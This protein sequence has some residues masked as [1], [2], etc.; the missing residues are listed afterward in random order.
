MT[1]L[2]LDCA[3]D[4]G[5]VA[6]GEPG[7]PG[8]EIVIG[9]RRHAAELVPAA[10]E[11]LRLAGRSWPDLA[12]V[13]VADGPGSFT[14][15]RIA[16]ATAAGLLRQRPGMPLLTAPSLLAAAWI[17][18]RVAAGPRVAAL[19]DALRGEVYAAIYEFGETIQVLLAPGLT[20]VDALAASGV[21]AS[22]AV[23]DGTRSRADLIRRW[24]G[25][26]PLPPPEGAPRAS[27]LI[28]LLGRG[29]VARVADLS[30]WEPAYG[31]PAEAQARWE[32][33]HGRPLPGSAGN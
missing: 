11:C 24:T 12:G 27:A 33:A 29:V 21:S 3:T 16:F 28:E 9:G 26:D 20:T 23:G 18:S 25:H 22:L 32:K 5:S 17:G 1:Y 15:L 7:S 13:I 8:P 31:R 2:A 6:V 19:F 30:D 14:G 4:V 10:R